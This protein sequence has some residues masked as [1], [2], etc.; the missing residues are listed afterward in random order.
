[1]GRG[2]GSNVWA[3]PPG[4]VYLTALTDVDPTIIPLLSIIACSAVI[5]TVR[6]I[7]PDQKVYNKWVND[8]FIEE[9]KVGGLLAKGLNYG[10][11]WL[12]VFGI[13]VNIHEAP[14]EGASCLQKYASKKLSV[15]DFSQKLVHNLIYAL[16]NKDESFKLYQDS[17]AFIGQHV[18]IYDI[19]L[20]NVE[21]EGI[22]KGINEYGHAILENNE[23]PVTGGRMRASK[24]QIEGFGARLKGKYTNEL[25]STMWIEEVD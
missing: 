3:S 23:K 9:K 13:G 2:Q 22:F 5:R 12:G 17:L 11:R 6:E 19:G 4:N 15:K 7:L 25:K 14:L 21:H 24:P 10:S 8:I 18:S 20:K 16:A 1:M